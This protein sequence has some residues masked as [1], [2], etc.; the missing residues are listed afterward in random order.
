MLAWRLRPSTWRHRSNPRG[1]GRMRGGH[2]AIARR[3]VMCGLSHHISR[4][5]S[6]AFFFL[7]NFVLIFWGAFLWFGQENKRQKLFHLFI[8]LFLK[9]IS[10]LTDLVFFI[11]IF[12]KHLKEFAV[13]LI[14]IILLS[15]ICFNLLLNTI[16]KQNKTKQKNTH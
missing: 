1:Y 8:Y 14:L 10:S 3:H 11:Y 13:K 16:Q 5:N 9:F 15:Y 7:F 6:S 4:F 2:V 12:I